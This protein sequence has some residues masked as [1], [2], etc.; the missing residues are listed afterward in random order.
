LEFFSKC[1]RNTSNNISTWTKPQKHYTD[2]STTFA[3]EF[4]YKELLFLIQL[5]IW[6]LTKYIFHLVNTVTTNMDNIDFEV[7]DS[8]AEQFSRPVFKTKQYGK[9]S[10]SGSIDSTTSTSS[11]SSRPRFSWISLASVDY[12]RAS[13]DLTG[14]G[15][16]TP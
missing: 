5:I 13:M 4:Q 15:L 6:S 2:H 12:G 10:K 14:K 8:V 9:K 16:Y 3:K 1:S 11:S 7:T